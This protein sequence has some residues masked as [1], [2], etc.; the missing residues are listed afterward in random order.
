MPHNHSPLKIS[1]V[2]WLVAVPLIVMSYHIYTFYESEPPVLR[3]SLAISFD[4]LVIAVF[5]FLKDEYIRRSARARKATW[6]TLYLLIG[7][8]LYVNVWAYWHLSLF[9]AIMSGSIFPFTVGLISYISMLREKEIE[10]DREQQQKKES[11]KKLIQTAS[12]EADWQ[13]MAA[14]Q[15][16]KDMRVTK[17]DVVNAFSQSGEEVSRDR[18]SGARNWRSVKRWWTKLKKGESL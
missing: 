1:S 9:R 12:T 13:L 6:A 18:F 4:L 10:A 15:T 14:D 2:N 8:Q 17:T 7:F 3:I 16:W 5:Y 11:A